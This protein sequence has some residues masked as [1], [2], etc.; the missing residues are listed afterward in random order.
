MPPGMLYVGMSRVRTLEAVTLVPV[1]NQYSNDTDVDRLLLKSPALTAVDPRVAELTARLEGAE[2]RAE[3]DTFS[4]AE[5]QMERR[6]GGSALS[7]VGVCV[8]CQ[9]KQCEYVFMPCGHAVACGD[10]MRAATARGMTT[11][12]SCRHPVARTHRVRLV[13]AGVSGAA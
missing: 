1:V 13:E 8:V 6:V 7:G 3:E 11:C 2:A 10:C 5:L 4:Q 9:R 12:F